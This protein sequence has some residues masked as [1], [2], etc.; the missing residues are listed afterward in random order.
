VKKKWVGTNLEDLVKRKKMGIKEFGRFG[1][2]EEM[3]RHEFGRFSYEEDEE[4]GWI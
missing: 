4:D 3:G 2:E 1:E